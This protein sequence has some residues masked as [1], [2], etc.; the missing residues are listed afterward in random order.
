MGKVTMGRGRR[1]SVLIAAAS[2]ACCWLGCTASPAHAARGFE[3]GIYEPDFGDDVA[4]QTRALD[5]TAQARAGFALI[6]VGWDNVAPSAPPPTPGNPG[7]PVYN[8]GTID[9]G[10]RDAKPGG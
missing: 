10:V 2:A 7:D 9:A 8:W 1:R 3:T 6:Y 5:R 4:A